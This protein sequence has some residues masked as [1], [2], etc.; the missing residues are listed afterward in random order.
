MG[1]GKEDR[2]WG[3]RMGL[4]FGERMELG[5]G[6]GEI[7]GLSWEREWWGWD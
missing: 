1:V 3:R 7:M 4:A 2:E 5:L 6:L